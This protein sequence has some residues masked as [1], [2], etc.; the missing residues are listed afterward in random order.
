MGNYTADKMF[1]KF[2]SQDN[3]LITILSEKVT[4]NFIYTMTW[5]IFWDKSLKEI[6]QN[7]NVDFL[8]KENIF[9]TSS[10]NT[11]AITK[12]IFPS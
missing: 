7:I 10:F 8:Y 9:S 4:K 6:Y 12:Y 3:T 2:H 11:Y 5:K 1:T